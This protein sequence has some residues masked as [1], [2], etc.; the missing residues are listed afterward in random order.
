MKVNFTTLMLAAA[1]LLASCSNDDALQTTVNDNDGRKAVTVTATLPEGSMTTR[2]A[3]AEDAAVARC[4]VQVLDAEGNLLYDDFS[5]VK[6][7]TASNNGFST[8]VYLNPN[9]TYTFLFWADSDNSGSAPTDLKAV[10]Y[11]QSGEVIAWVGKENATWSATGV[12][13]ELKHAVARITVHSSTAVE[14]SGENNFTVVVPTTY[15]TYNVYSGDVSGNQTSYTYTDGNSSCTEDGD[16]CHFYVLVAANQE[17][18]TLTLQYNGVLGNPAVTVDNVPLKAN[19][20]T[21]LSGDVYN[22]GL[23]NGTI[24]ATISEEWTDENRNF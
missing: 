19:W 23:T 6:Q 22:L 7:M 5:D 1:A 8:T 11:N 12:T 2:A 9:D 10:T 17:N 4:F 13:A 16:L 20:H 14:L 21:T 15:T 3:G 18:Q 24:A